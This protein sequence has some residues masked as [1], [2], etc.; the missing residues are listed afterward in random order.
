MYYPQS[1]RQPLLFYCALKYPFGHMS[2]GETSCDIHPRRLC[3]CQQL[4]KQGRMFSYTLEKS[5]PNILTPLHFL[6][7]ASAPK[8]R[9]VAKSLIAVYSGGSEGTSHSARRYCRP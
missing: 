2:N 9:A 6:L 8:T 3:V 5:T 4:P 1:L 7:Q